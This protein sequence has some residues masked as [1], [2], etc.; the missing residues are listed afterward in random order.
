MV[1]EVEPGACIPFGRF[2][3][4]CT[5]CIWTS[6][7]LLLK[8]PVLSTLTRIVKGFWLKLFG[9]SAFVEID[10]GVSTVAE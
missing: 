5:L 4:T 2:R 6:A 10:F 7:S 8:P 9:S 3:T 1:R